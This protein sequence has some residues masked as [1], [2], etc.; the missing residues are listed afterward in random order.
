MEQSAAINNLELCLVTLDHQSRKER[1]CGPEISAC[2]VLC[3]LS[4]PGSRRVYATQL[5]R[6]DRVMTGVLS[7]ALRLVQCINNASRL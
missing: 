4:G 1:S 3:V 5:G 6:C 2:R 7:H